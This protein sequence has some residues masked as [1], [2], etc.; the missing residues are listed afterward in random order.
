MPRS[1]ENISEL[2][3]ILDLCIDA[4]NRGDSIEQCLARHPEYADELEPLLIT[5]QEIIAIPHPVPSPELKSETKRALHVSLP[6][7][8]EMRLQYALDNCI[9]LLIQGKSVEHCLELYPEFSVGL[10][11]LLTV[12]STLREGINVKASLRF[13]EEARRRVLARVGKAGINRWLPWVSWPRWAYRGAL[14]AAALL[15]MVS[16]GHVTVRSSSDS[17][18]GDFLYPV[19]GLSETVQMKLATSNEGEAKLHVEL[20]SRRAQELAEAAVDGDSEMVEELLVK[21]QGHLEE[22]PRLMSEKQFH[23]ALE[24]VLQGD[25][26]MDHTQLRE[27]LVMLGQDIRMNDDRLKGAMDEAPDHM[28][29]ELEAVIARVR[30]HYTET[31]AALED[32]HSSEDLDSLN[33]VRLTYRK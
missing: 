1:M 3:H 30:T 27:L 26:D 22:A 29:P 18:P 6:G 23:E 10:E 14:A 33:G 8:E 20:A 21:L 15:I 31:I 24:L 7:P 9:D 11:P 28:H 25:G 5:A 17:G 12:A 4:L 19:K 16:A 13:K 2:E 32:K